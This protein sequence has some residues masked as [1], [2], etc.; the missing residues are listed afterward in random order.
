MPNSKGKAGHLSRNKRLK[1]TC[2]FGPKWLPP[3]FHSNLKHYFSTHAYDFP[4]A[5]VPFEDSLMNPL[6]KTS[7][8]SWISRKKK[9]IKT[10]TEISMKES[11]QQH[12]Q[13]ILLHNILPTKQTKPVRPFLSCM[14]FLSCRLEKR[15][16]APTFCPLPP[17]PWVPSSDPGEESHPALHAEPPAELLPITSHLTQHSS[18]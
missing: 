17:S 13:G 3:S 6:L 18:P 14:P 1:S 16:L 11:L 7:L 8:N 12:S 10:E 15:S 4:L 2:E 9:I 5:V